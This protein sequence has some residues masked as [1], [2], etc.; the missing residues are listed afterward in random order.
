MSS[1]EIDKNWDRSAAVAL[2]LKLVVADVAA[3]HCECGT[4]ATSTAQIGSAVVACLVDRHWDGGPVVATAA[5]S[6]VQIESAAVARLVDGHWDGGPVVAAGATN[7]AQI[8]S[9]AMASRAVPAAIAPAMHDAP[10][11]GNLPVLQAAA[12]VAVVASAAFATTSSAFAL[13]G[14]TQVQL[15]N[16]RSAP[17]AVRWTHRCFWNR[18]GCFQ[19]PHHHAR[20]P[21][22]SM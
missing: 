14:C 7:V 8:E 4:G 3:M 12:R 16:A 5:K 18:N 19:I 11:T 20:G 22:Q 15:G 9:A 17:A 13:A 6:M 2:V 1:P 21:Q 10:E